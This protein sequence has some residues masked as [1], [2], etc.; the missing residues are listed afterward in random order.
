MLGN[1]LE[2][3][4]G[5]YSSVRPTFRQL[6][7]NVNSCT[8]AFYRAGNLAEAMLE[9]LQGGGGR[10]SGFV[11][12]I[13]IQTTHMGHRS[14]RTIKRIGEKSARQQSFICEE[15]GNAAIT[16]EQYFLR[17]MSCLTRVHRIAFDPSIF[18]IRY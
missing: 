11:K 2:A 18:R 7:V 16:V 10:L 9:F 1:G 8:T 5:Y 12:G 13:R 15:Y 17:S 6:M 14:K 3:L 4:K